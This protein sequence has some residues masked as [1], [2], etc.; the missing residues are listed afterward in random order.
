MHPAPYSPPPGRPSLMGVTLAAVAGSVLLVR[1]PG[2][3]RTGSAL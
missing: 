2:G 3:E 1:R